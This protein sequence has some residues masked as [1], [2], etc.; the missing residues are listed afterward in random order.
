MKITF[1]Q[2]GDSV[3]EIRKD[4]AGI[5][6][7]SINDNSI[8]LSRRDLKNFNQTLKFL[9]EV[10][11]ETLASDSFESPA[12]GNVYVNFEHP[13]PSNATISGTT[14]RT[15]SSNIDINEPPF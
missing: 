14:I 8:P 6:W 11:P 13:T 3:L 10:Q 9:D 2:I 7:L 1:K 4:D 15:H 12:L 5:V